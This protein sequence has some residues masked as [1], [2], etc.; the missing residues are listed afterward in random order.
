MEHDDSLSW[1]KKWLSQLSVSITIIIIIIIIICFVI[2]L[3]SSLSLLQHSTF[4]PPVRLSLSLSLPLSPS[5]SPSPPRFQ[6]ALVFQ[7]NIA[8]CARTMSRKRRKKRRKHNR[9]SLSLFLSIFLPFLC[10]PFPLLSGP[11]VPSFLG[12]RHGKS[13]S[14]CRVG[15]NS[16]IDIQFRGERELSSSFHPR[17]WCSSEREDDGPTARKAF[18]GF[19]T[20]WY[21]PIFHGYARFHRSGWRSDRSTDQHHRR[22]I[23]FPGVLVVSPL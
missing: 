18:D 15:W 8:Q 9:A 10:F 12:Q 11:A 23:R 20:S 3:L 7:G 21:R 19:G 2:L 13:G 17:A 6:L 5:F 22:K 4:S 16:S 14:T 1:E